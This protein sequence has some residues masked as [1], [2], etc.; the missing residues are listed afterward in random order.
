MKLEDTY[1]ILMH[2]PLW[3]QIDIAQYTSMIACMEGKQRSFR[4]GSYIVM[5]GDEVT[6]I[7]MI[8]SGSVKVIKEDYDGNIFI[9]TELGKSD[10][11]GE[12]FACAG[13][14]RSPVTIQATTKTEVMFIDF[15][16]VLSTCSSAC[17]FHTK[18]IENMLSL[19]AQ[20][21]LLLNQKIDI[22]SKRSTREKLLAFLEMFRIDG[23]KFLIPYNREEMA[24][25]LCVD[26]S[27][28]SYELSKMRD[29]GIIRYKKN[30]FEILSNI[31]Q[32]PI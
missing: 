2:N 19:I 21:N 24:L 26:R 12:A 32:N 8:L 10:L 1:D 18:L 22:L 5:A 3:N 14:K 20:K 4:K 7:G 15:Q 29:E 23:N 30:E 9:M 27:A 11:F 6:H 16:K 17:S 25:Y 28:M 13:V 31:L